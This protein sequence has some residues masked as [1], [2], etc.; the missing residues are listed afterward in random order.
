MP[1]EPRILAGFV[2]GT[3]ET[4]L[5]HE[6]ASGRAISGRIAA[7]TLARVRRALPIAWLPLRDD[8]EIT[9]RL[10]EAVGEERAEQI[11]RE[12]MAGSMEKG[13]LAPLV[14]GA[15]ALLGR[16]PER[17]LRWASKVWFTIYRDAG[18]LVYA[19]EPDGARLELLRAPA[20]VAES[21]PYLVGVAAAVEGAM[22]A[23][24]CAVRCEL[25]ET[26][27]HPVLSVRW[28]RTSS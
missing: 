7:E 12:A 20:L 19:E 10:F 28:T 5:R 24:G 25:R 14:R 22:G 3:L 2:Q 26:E 16:R 18:D 13:F 1:D 15:V 11:F 27:P 21:R 8:L 4:A 9:E 23:L 17:L 6:Q